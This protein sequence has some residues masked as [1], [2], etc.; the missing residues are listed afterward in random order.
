MILH[1]LFILGDVKKR[2]QSF[3][4]RHASLHCHGYVASMVLMILTEHEKIM[5]L[6]ED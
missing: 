5:E 4:V 2:G 1:I 3:N 6:M